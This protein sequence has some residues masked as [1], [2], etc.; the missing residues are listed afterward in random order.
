MQH[1]ITTPPPP[2]PHFFKRISWTAVFVGAL[3]GVGLGFLLNLF[4]VAIGLG[5]FSVNDNGGLVLTIGGLLGLIIA[6]VVSMV[7]AGYAAGYLGRY[8]TPKRNYGILYGFVTWSLALILSAVFAAH[9]SNYVAVY[10][11]GITHSGLVSGKNLDTTSDT[12]LPAERNDAA[13]TSVEPANKVAPTTRDLAWGAFVVFILFF[14]G[15]VSTC[16]GAC[17]GM[18]SMRED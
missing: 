10:T 5:A 17:W 16:F 2:A 3:V 13:A 12:L 8:Y 14:I 7:A 4:G 11:A 9:V 1:T 6:T 18:N 15:A